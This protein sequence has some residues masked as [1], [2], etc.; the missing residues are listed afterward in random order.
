VPPSLDNA[1]TRG[2]LV[3]VLGKEELSVIVR[4]LEHYNIRT[5]KFAETVQFYDDVLGMKAK[6]P[7]M[8]RKDGPASWIYD[9]SGVAAIHLTRVDPADPVNSYARAAKYRG[10]EPDASFQG[11]GAIDHVAFEC[12]GLDEFKGRLRLQQVPFVENSFPT[13]GL[14]QLFVKDPNGITLELNFRSAAA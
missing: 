10:A 5:T 9:D 14:H 2:F 4:R 7:P 13:A 8:A 11:S 1:S 3:V 12:D 6:T